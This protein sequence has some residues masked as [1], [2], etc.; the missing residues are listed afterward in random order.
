MSSENESAGAL[1]NSEVMKRTAKFSI[2]Y[3][4]GLKCARCDGIFIGPQAFKEHMEESHLCLPPVKR[5]KLNEEY[6]Q[7]SSSNNIYVD[8]KEMQHYMN[9]SFE[10][11]KNLAEKVT[12]SQIQINENL[13]QKNSEQG[14]ILAQKE[15]IHNLKNEKNDLEITVKVLTSNLKTANDKVDK[16]NQEITDQSEEF[17]RSMEKI[18]EEMKSL[19]EQNQT[20]E[21]QKNYFKSSVIKQNQM[22]EDQKNQFKSKEQLMEQK[23]FTVFKENL[24]LKTQNKDQTIILNKSQEEVINLAEKV[25][26]QKSKLNL[27]QLI[28]K[29]LEQNIQDSMKI[30][31]MVQE[32][33]ALMSEK[34]SK[35][36]AQNHELVLKNSKSR[37]E[38]DNL[39]RTVDDQKSKLNLRQ[40]KIEILE[41]NINTLMD[42]FLP[43]DGTEKTFFKLLEEIEY[44]KAQYTT[45]K[46]EIEHLGTQLTNSIS[47]FEALKKKKTVN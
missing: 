13:L 1:N 10:N 14:E 27:R 41:K 34:L 11:F 30:E 38:V 33:K 5:K 9:V 39:K 45:Q 47:N 44:I 31:N 8:L 16:A 20:L 21:I 15:T 36:D 40:Q 22:L 46:E 32:E 12:S 3:D 19:I 25:E 4:V 42:K 6:N 24:K 29:N 17:S 23:S 37:E 35:F 43:N 26:D 7:K 2:D 28:I 18:K